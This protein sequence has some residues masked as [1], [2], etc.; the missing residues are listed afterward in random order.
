MSI[1]S[2]Q[3]KIFEVGEV[4]GSISMNAVLC[5]EG[6]LVLNIHTYLEQMPKPT[7]S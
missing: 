2:F 6:D 5:E 7:F 4:G 1:D 3:S